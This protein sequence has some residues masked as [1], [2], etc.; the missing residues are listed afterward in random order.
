MVKETKIEVV[1][2]GNDLS[3]VAAYCEAAATVNFWELGASKLAVDLTAGVSYYWIE[4]G[5]FTNPLA[6]D[7]IDEVSFVMYEADGDEVVKFALLQ[8]NVT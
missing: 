2:A 8:D 3:A 1:F 6:G 4:N 7:D 5:G